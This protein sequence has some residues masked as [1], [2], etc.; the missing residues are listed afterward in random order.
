MRETTNEVLP[1]HLRSCRARSPVQ[2]LAQ[3]AGKYL[4]AGERERIEATI[5]AEREADAGVTL[6]K[7]YF[8]QA[9][10]G[11]IKI[12]FSTNPPSRVET[13]RTAHHEELTLLGTIAGDPGREAFW[14]RAFAGD[15][16]RGE[17]FRPSAALLD[18]I[19][20]RCPVGS[21]CVRG[22]S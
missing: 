5:A 12:G 18:A 1:R 15:H 17:W 9:A 20:Q 10:S 3:Y 11:P 21:R 14:H 2:A 19:A 4:P 8:V 6:G 22:L 13:L 16:I 7:I